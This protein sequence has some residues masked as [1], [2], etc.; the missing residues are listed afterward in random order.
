[1]KGPR[2]L[3]WRH[4]KEACNRVLKEEDKQ[5][6]RPYYGLVDRGRA[7]VDVQSEKVAIKLYNAMHAKKQTTDGKEVDANLRLLHARREGD[8]VRPTAPV[9]AEAQQAR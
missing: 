6:A 8:A 9:A 2:S 1:M 3:G 5:K 4:V 7:V